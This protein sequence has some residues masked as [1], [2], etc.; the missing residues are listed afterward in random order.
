MGRKLHRTSKTRRLTFLCYRRP[1]C[2]TWLCDARGPIPAISGQVTRATFLRNLSRKNFA[3]QDEKLCL[4]CYHPCCKLRQRWTHGYFAQHVAATRYAH[5]VVTDVSFQNSLISL[6]LKN[7]FPLPF[8]NCGNPGA[9]TLWR[10][11]LLHNKWKKMLPALTYNNKTASAYGKNDSILFK[12]K[13]K[14]TQNRPWKD[15]KILVSAK[16]NPEWTYERPVLYLKYTYN[17][18]EAFA[19]SA[20]VMKTPLFLQSEI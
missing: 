6:T 4:T 13:T 12:W 10:A 7:F 17:D 5:M 20:R 14:L 15:Y 9:I 2:T 19:R 1:F 18:F 11:T 8:P 16:K 3:L